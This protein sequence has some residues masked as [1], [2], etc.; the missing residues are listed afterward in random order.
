MCFKIMSSLMFADFREIIEPAR[1]CSSCPRGVAPGSCRAARSSAPDNTAPHPPPHQ[2][3]SSSATVLTSGL[4]LSYFGGHI[5][6]LHMSR[7]HT[8]N[9]LLPT[10]ESK[11]DNDLFRWGHFWLWLDWQFLYE[12]FDLVVIWRCV[13]W[14]AMIVRAG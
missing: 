1:I 8:I 14:E 3:A 6:G 9:P 5:C 4:D 12:Q 7:A 11:H 13:C 2:P 10:P